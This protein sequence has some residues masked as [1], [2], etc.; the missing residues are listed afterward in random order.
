MN[1]GD[2][3][4]LR[5]AL[6]LLKKADEFDQADCAHQANKSDSARIGILRR[7]LEERLNRVITPESLV[8]IN[9][10]TRNPAKCDA[11]ELGQMDTSGG[12]ALA[13]VALGAVLAVGLGY[14]DLALPGGVAGG[15]ALRFS[16]A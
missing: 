12:T 2:F 9:A 10:S 11:M 1:F 8:A 5:L 15:C 4:Y 3:D 16:V 13:G 7:F 6:T 14:A